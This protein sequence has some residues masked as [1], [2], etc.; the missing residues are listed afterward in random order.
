LGD[1]LHA[2]GDDAA[3]S[4]GSL[5]LASRGFRVVERV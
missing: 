1:A 2:P 5:P 3:I 4:R